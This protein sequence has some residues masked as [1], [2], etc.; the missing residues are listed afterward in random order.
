MVLCMNVYIYIYIRNNYCFPT[1]TMITPTH[2][3]I[4]LYVHCLLVSFRG[5]FIPK[6]IFNIQLLK[7]S[8]PM[9][10]TMCLCKVIY[11]RFEAPYCLKLQGQS[12]QAK[13]HDLEILQDRKNE[14]Q[15]ITSHNIWIFN[16]TVFK[17][18]LL[19]FIC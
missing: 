8:S 16:S 5:A 15:G 7:I 2:L 9:V 13:H 19:F 6:I 10:V 11:R 1:A 14:R 17:L 18:L 4:T 12:V 3:N